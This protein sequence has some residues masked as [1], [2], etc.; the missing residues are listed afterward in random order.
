MIFGKDR[1]RGLRLNGHRP[2]VVTIGANGI[3]EDDILVHDPTDSLIAYLLSTIYW[4][5]FPVPVGVI[6]DITRPTLDAMITAQIEQAVAARGKGDLQ[7]LL[8][9]GETWTVE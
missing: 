2:E 8:D 1:D 9:S 3:T 6:R 4:P 7:R 5:D